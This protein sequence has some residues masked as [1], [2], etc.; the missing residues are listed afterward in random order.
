[1]QDL[2]RT[3]PVILEKFGDDTSVRESVVFA[4]WRK[5]AGDMLKD[6]TVPV[7]IAEKRLTV[8]VSGKAWKRH[9][10]DLSGELIFKIN[11]MLGSETVKFIEF[12]E[13]SDTVKAAN[14]RQRFEDPIE[15]AESEITPELRQAATAIHDMEMR[16]KFLLAAGSCIAREK[17]FEAKN[18]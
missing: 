17:R 4:A 10:E 13:D 6:H 1:M 9:L 15:I 8:A 3:L 7:S 11:R 2:F 16:R 14:Q 18:E 12:V 5:A